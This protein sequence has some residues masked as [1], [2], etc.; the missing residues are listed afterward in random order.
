MLQYQFNELDD[1]M[2]KLEKGQNI[3]KTAEETAVELEEEMS[4]DAKI[5]RKFITQ[6]VAVATADNTKN[7]ENKIKKSEKGVRDRVSGESSSK[8]GTRG[9]GHASNKK[10]LRPKQTPSQDHLRNLRLNRHTAERASFG[11][12]RGDDNKKQAIP[13]VVRQETGEGRKQRAPKAHQH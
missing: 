1:R 11:A 2:S 13:T 6:Q 7:Y 5:I 9:G 3:T 8:N 10:N 12:P 4:M